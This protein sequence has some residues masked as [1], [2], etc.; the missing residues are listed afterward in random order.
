[1]AIENY[2]QVDVF[3]GVDVGKGK[4]HAVALDRAGRTRRCPMMKRSCVSS[5]GSSNS[6]AECSSSWTN[7]RQSGLFR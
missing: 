6:M 4:H 1:M 2:E 3:I 5:S 7:R